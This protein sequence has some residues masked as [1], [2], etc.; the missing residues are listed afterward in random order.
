MSQVR[1]FRET[2]N[3]AFF[4]GHC[5]FL[6]FRWRDSIK[7]CQ[8]LNSDII[9]KDESKKNY[10]KIAWSNNLFYIPYVCKRLLKILKKMQD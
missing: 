1:V 7:F 10:S 6:H 2:A 4:I 8:M 3:L 5:K 9:L